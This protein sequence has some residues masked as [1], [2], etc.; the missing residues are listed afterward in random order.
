MATFLFATFLFCLSGVVGAVAAYALGREYQDW[1]WSRFVCGEL[2]IF[3]LLTVA[4]LALP[5]EVLVV[6]MFG[7]CAA[8]FAFRSFWELM[9]RQRDRAVE[10]ENTTHQ[11]RVHTPYTPGDIYDGKH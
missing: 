8:G 7:F 1:P 6:P 4:L 11:N 2:T 9:L 10:H 5:Q 3:T